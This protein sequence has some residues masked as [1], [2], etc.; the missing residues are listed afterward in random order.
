MR[1]HGI[2]PS[3]LQPH[4]SLTYLHIPQFFVKK[5]G[6]NEKSFFSYLEKVVIVPRRIEPGQ[7]LD[8]LESITVD[9]SNIKG[10]GIMGLTTTLFAEDDV[11]TATAVFTPRPN[12]GDAEELWFQ[13]AEN[14]SDQYLRNELIERYMPLVRRHAG[15]T[16]AKLRESV[17]LDDL[18]SAG[19][20][21]LMDAINAFDVSRGVKFE[22]FCT[23]RVLGAIDRK[24]T[25]LNS[26]H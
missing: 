2:P 13:F 21:G 12:L 14:P 20:F 11:A 15:H 10:I 3:C 24:S 7:L 19:T 9:I 16:W 25:R 23:Q 22:T 5:I 26:S 18:I 4:A 17:E 1:F 6:K 8:R